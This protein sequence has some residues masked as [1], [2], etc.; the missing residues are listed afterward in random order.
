MKETYATFCDLACNQ[1]SS[2]EIPLSDLLHILPYITPRFY[3]ISSS[4]SL[5]PD[6]VHLTIATTEVP[7][8]TTVGNKKITKMFSGLCTGYLQ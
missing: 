3:T 2:L 6:T 7:L 4:S 5:Y 1:L 8:T